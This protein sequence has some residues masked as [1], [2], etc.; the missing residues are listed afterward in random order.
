[1]LARDVSCRI[2]Q[3]IFGTESAHLIPRTEDHWFNTNQMLRYSSRPEAP[4]TNS[5]DDARNVL[6]LR[7]DLHHLFDQGRFVFL[8][9][10]G[11]W[12]VHVLFGLPNEELAALYHNVTVQPLSEVSVE[13]LFTR[14][15][16]TVLSQSIFLR[17]DTDR[18]LAV[19]EGDKVRIEIVSGVDYRIKF[20]PPGAKSRSQSPKK[21]VRN[22][23]SE[24]QDDDDVDV[25]GPDNWDDDRGRKRWRQCS[26]SSAS[27]SLRRL[28]ASSGDECPV[29]LRDRYLVTV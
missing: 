7:S 8:P 26:S 10:R 29:Q 17:A 4:G 19:V 1:V 11:I 23:G 5:A 12:V 21:R 2:S 22:A 28:D 9:K 18:R 24:N 15:A 3:N 20:A 16:W 13:F 25:D 14:F 6:L 27:T